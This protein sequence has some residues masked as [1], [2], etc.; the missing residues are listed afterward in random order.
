MGVHSQ[1]TGGM[2]AEASPFS[3]SAGQHPAFSAGGRMKS[4]GDF[5][6]TSDSC[7]VSVSQLMLLHRVLPTSY[8]CACQP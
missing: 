6:V 4:P 1:Q 7:P 2:Y 5:L 8:P 3:S